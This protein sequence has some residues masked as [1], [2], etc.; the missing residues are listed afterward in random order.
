M[1]FLLVLFSL[2]VVI[3]SNCNTVRREFQLCT[4]QAHATYTAAFRSGRD[5]RDSFNARKTCNYMTSALEVCP[6]KLKKDGCASDQ[7]VIAMK[8]MQM[9]SILKMVKSSVAEWDSCKCP[10]I[11]AHLDR[12]KSKEGAV[13]DE[14]CPT[15][16]LLSGDIFL[17]GNL[18][19]AEQSSDVQDFD[20]SYG[21]LIVATGVVLA[22]PFIL[23]FF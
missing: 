7:E 8:D 19:E 20:L 12:M 11:K 3:W 10:P 1:R 18:V 22:K 4:Q 2:F 5:G 6:E 14:E 16:P 23:A 9:R 21:G 15:T 17:M 13:V